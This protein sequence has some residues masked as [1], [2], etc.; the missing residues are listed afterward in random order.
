MTKFER[1]LVSVKNRY[2]GW[3]SPD[4]DPKKIDK[5]GL[6]RSNYPDIGNGWIKGWVVNTP[7]KDTIIVCKHSCPSTSEPNNK[8]YVIDKFGKTIERTIISVQNNSYK[9]NGNPENG[10]FRGEDDYFMGGDI[11]ICKVNEPFPN[12]VKAYNFS[13]DPNIIQRNAYTFNQNGKLTKARVFY[14]ENLAWIFGKARFG[15]PLTSGDS[16]TVWFVWNGDEWNVLTH[17]S[18]GMAGEGPYYGHKYIYNQI[19]NNL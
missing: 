11:S 5:S 18:R 19:K 10:S 17:T 12:T 3:L 1:F 8:I 16:G 2:F 15:E 7:Q 6:V 14:S 13:T 9:I 4:P